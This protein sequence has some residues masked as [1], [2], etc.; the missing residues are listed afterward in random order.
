MNDSSALISCSQQC[1]PVFVYHLMAYKITIREMSCF[2]TSVYFS[3]SI[4]C[5]VLFFIIRILTGEG[6]AVG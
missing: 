6:E 2:L 5:T 1:L 4:K 3:E